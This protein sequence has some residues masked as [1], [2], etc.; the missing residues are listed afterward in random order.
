[1]SRLRC[2]PVSRDCGQARKHAF[3]TSWGMSHRIVGATIMV[4]GDEKGLKLPPRVAPVQV[5]IVP[6]WRTDD[7]R[8][9]V[10][11]AITRTEAQLAP[12]ARVRVDRRE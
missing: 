3:G 5:V 7:E 12:V 6:I 11:A 2:N 10:E 1:M 9:A 8:T 4:H